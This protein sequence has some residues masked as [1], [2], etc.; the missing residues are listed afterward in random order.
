MPNI[1]KILHKN[2]VNVNVFAVGLGLPNF[3]K[4]NKKPMGAEVMA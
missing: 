4:I 2:P 3:V 1:L